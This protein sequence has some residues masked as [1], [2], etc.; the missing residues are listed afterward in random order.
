MAQQYKGDSFSTFLRGI[1]KSPTPARE[2][3]KILQVLRAESPLAVDELMKRAELPF[4][5]FA[6]AL[7]A[8]QES[9]FVQV[10]GEPG[11][12]V[13]RLTPGGRRGVVLKR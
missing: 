8:L 3:A 9:G 5:E 10:E 7:E 2:S 4:D 12:Q 6:R 13:V 11:K 1:K